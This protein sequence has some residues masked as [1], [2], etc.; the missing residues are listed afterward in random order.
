LMAKIREEVHK[1]LGYTCS[2]VG[3]SVLPSVEAVNLTCT[4]SSRE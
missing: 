4:R 3:G 2:A 1:R